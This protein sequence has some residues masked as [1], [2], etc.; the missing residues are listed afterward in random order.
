M[1]SQQ[2]VTLLIDQDDV[3]AEYIGAVTEAFNKKYHTHF[4]KEDC[5]KW[6]LYSVFGDKIET[7]MHEPKLF[8]NLEPTKNAIETFK[9]LYESGLFDMYIVSAAHPKVVEAKLEWI[10]QHL[11]FFPTK[12]FIVCS[13]KSRIRGD[14][15]LDDGMHNI[16]E[17][18]AAGGKG[19]V[20]ERPH[21][22]YER[23]NYV[24]VADWLEFERYII[25]TCYP[26]KVNEYYA[27]HD[28]AI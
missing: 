13:C 4:K 17:F 9:R 2:K 19:V 14:Y 26:E 28:I 24:S 11:P 16:E 8:R 27:K 5:V 15:L 18:E 3:L 25:E 20:F 22:K 7:V 10:K 23:K 6:D 1:M 12:H 21:N